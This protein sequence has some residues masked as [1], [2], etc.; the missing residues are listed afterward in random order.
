MSVLSRGY[1]PVPATMVQLRVSCHIIHFNF[2]I[3]KY[4]L[5][6]VVFS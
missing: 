6:L 3:Q 4:L 5:A 1:T 2:C